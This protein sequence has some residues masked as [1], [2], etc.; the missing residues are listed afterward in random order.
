MCVLTIM[1]A[2]SCVAIY[3]YGKHAFIRKMRS[4]APFATYRIDIKFSQHARFISTRNKFF[5]KLFFFSFLFIS[6]R[7]SFFH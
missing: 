1:Q 7:F 5:K 2:M 4:T 3:L 6:F